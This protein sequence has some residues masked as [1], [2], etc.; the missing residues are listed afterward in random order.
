MSKKIKK[1]EELMTYYEFESHYLPEKYKERLK[2][3][4]KKRDD[5]L[6][7]V[8]KRIVDEVKKDFCL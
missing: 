6:Q 5:Y 7:I 2:E 4:E 1:T 3:A 8:G